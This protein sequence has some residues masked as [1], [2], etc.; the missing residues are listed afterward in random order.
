MSRLIAATAKTR[1]RTDP[2]DGD[3]VRKRS[4]TLSGH[5]TS[6]SLEDAFWDAL[7]DIAAERGISITA[8]VNEVDEARGVTAL[9]QSLRAYALNWYR[10]R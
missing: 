10:N 1:K 6:V 4:L 5:R 3:R 7:N 8:L 9:S 2:V